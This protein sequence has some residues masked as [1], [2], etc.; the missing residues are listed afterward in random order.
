M[1]LRGLVPVD[2]DE[3]MK[4]KELSE[5]PSNAVTVDDDLQN[6]VDMVWDQM[7]GNFMVD[8]NASSGW[9]MFSAGPGAAVPF[10][11]LGTGHG[12]GNQGWLI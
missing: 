9:D 2:E 5:S 10:V 7:L 3:D 8:G 12:E 6:N 11:N 4:E 1:R